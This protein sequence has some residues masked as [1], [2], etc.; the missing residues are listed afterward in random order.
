M[1]VIFFVPTLSMT[2]VALIFGNFLYKTHSKYHHFHY[3]YIKFSTRLTENIFWIVEGLFLNS[4][5]VKSNY[6]AFQLCI[7]LSDNSFRCKTN[8]RCL[9]CCLNLE[10]WFTLL[11]L[12][13]AVCQ[14]DLAVFVDCGN[15]FGLREAYYMTECLTPDFLCFQIKV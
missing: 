15:H 12:A 4:P 13:D 6:F 7:W 1:L 5:T 14:T 8:G 10:R 2:E 9:R 3:R 11:V